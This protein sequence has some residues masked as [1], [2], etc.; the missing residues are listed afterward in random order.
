M[1]FCMN[2]GHEVDLAWTH[3]PKC[4]KIQ[5]ESSIVVEA[6]EEK[7]KDQSI[8][9]KELDLHTASKVKRL[10]SGTIDLMVGGGLAFSTYSYL[11]KKTFFTATNLRWMIVRALIPLIPALYFLFKDSLGGKSIGK[12]ILNLSAVNVKSEKPIGIVDSLLR[13]AMLAIVAIPVL[14]WIAFFIITL[15]ITVQI[16]IGRPQRVGDQ[17]AKTIVIEDSFLQS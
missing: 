9:N 17:F 4:G 8:D 6:Q 15:V 10:V 11:L 16:I 14:G 2:C 1:P 12:L 3:C 13:N 5:N 7:K